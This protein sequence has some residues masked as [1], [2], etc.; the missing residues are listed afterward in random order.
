MVCRVWI[1]GTEDEDHEV[2]RW[3]VGE[4]QPFQLF[5]L[6]TAVRVSLLADGEEYDYI[7]DRFRNMPMPEQGFNLR[8]TLTMRSKTVH[9][10]GDMARFILA[11][12]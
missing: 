10:F 8:G 12:L 1:D 9:F 11:N 6:E 4:T 2:Q 7:F 3:L 5:K